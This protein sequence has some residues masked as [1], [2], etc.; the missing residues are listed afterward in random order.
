M[1][2]VAVAPK[3]RKGSVEDV[4]SPPFHLYGILPLRS[5]LF[6]FPY[7]SLLSIPFH[8][9]PPCQCTLLYGVPGTLDRTRNLLCQTRKGIES[10]FGCLKL[11]QKRETPK[12]QKI[13]FCNRTITVIVWEI[14]C[15]LCFCNSRLDALGE[16]PPL[17]LG[18]VVHVGDLLLER[19]PVHGDGFGGGRGIE[20][21]LLPDAAVGP[22][23]AVAAI[24]LSAASVDAAATALRRA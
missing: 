21:P 4:L 17:H 23:T 24:G 6:S 3:K 14:L 7:P 12:G 11:E 10:Q 20:T 16:R 2:S 1:G 5:F 13:H 22:A 15:W 18:L 9:Y 8:P 19:V